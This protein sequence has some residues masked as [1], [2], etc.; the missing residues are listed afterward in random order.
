[1]DF[2]ELYLSFTQ[3]S[4][5]YT[6]KGINADP[7]QIISSHRME[8]LLKKCYSRSIAQFNAIQVLDSPTQEV[9]T[10][11]QLVLNKHQKVFEI[12]NNL[13]PSRGEHDHGIPLIPGSQPPNVCPYR[14][15]FSQ[16]NEI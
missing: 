4:H 5:T 13:P 16:N 1:M 6:L 11:L 14:H 8:K 12:P 3:D 9:H 2:K 15:H 7:P 10:D